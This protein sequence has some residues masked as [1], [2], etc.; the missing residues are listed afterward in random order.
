M[1]RVVGDVESWTAAQRVA[2]T[3]KA[4]EWIVARTAVEAV[5]AVSPLESV[6]GVV[7]RRAVE[8]SELCTP[9]RAGLGEVLAAPAACGPAGTKASVSP[10][11]PAVVL[12]VATP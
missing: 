11:A 3:R 10:R 12:R 6:R 1:G 8:S 9:A 2:D 7:V 4:V 5:A